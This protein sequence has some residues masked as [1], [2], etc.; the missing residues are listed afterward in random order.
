M[1]LRRGLVP[2]GGIAYI[3][4][5]AEVASVM[6]HQSTKRADLTHMMMEEVM[7]RWMIGRW[8]FFFAALLAGSAPASFAEDFVYVVRAGDN[9]WNLTQRYLKSINYWPAIQE[10][11]QIVDSTGLPPGRRLRIPLQWMRATAVVARVVDLR[12][13]A[14]MSLAEQRMPLKAGMSVT[15]GASLR[16]GP[17][18]SLT[19][20]YPDGSRSLLGSDSELRLA[21]LAR[22]PVSSAQQVRV[23]LTRGHLEN[24]VQRQQ[25]NGGGRF[26]IETPAAVAAVRGTRFRV[27]ASGEAVRAETL[28]GSVLLA[29]RAGR[30]VVAGGHGSLAQVGRAPVKPLAL[31]AAPQLDELPTRVERLPLRLDFPAVAGALRYRTQLAPLPHFSV[32]ESDRLSEA[33]RATSSAEL[34]NGSY[35]LRVRAIDGNGLEGLDAERQIVIHARPE[36]PLLRQ[37]APDGIVIDERPEFLWSEGSMPGDYHFQLGSD[38]ALSSLLVDVKR[39]ARP[40]LALPEPLPPGQYY[41]R[42]ARRTQADGEGP[43][44]DVQHFRRLPAGP[45]VEPPRQAGNRLDLC[46]RAGSADERYQIQLSPDQAFAGSVIEAETDNAAL[47]IDKPPAGVYYVRVRA[48]APGQPPSPWGETQRVEIT[49]DYWPILLIVAA[50]LLIVF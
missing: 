13:Q 17:E 33:P 48:L 6:T 50:T 28:D 36:P 3:I 11:N 45:S 18:S 15:L 19:I 31:L 46:W 21:D 43:F 34:A 16:T 42:V 37:P 40:P 9:P 23:E 27:T 2:Y 4:S 20:E 30:A 24:A 38:R 35:L 22:L 39:I 8:G 32:I 12:G 1:G 49:R 47:S 26:V 29:N 44:S 25:R 5:F 7:R 14:E 10:Y 41:W